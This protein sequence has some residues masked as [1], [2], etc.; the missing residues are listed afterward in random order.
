MAGAAGWAVCGPVEG[1]KGA[2]T[3]QFEYHPPPLRLLPVIS[4]LRA[5]RDSRHGFGRRSSLPPSQSRLALQL[6]VDRRLPPDGPVW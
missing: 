6:P 3:R 2:A 1:P 5:Q 4:V